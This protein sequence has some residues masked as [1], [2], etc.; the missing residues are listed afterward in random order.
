MKKLLSLALALVLVCMTLALASCDLLEGD[1]KSKLDGKTPEELYEVSQQKLKEATSYSV[2]STQEISMTY[3]EETMSM[4]QTVISKING[5]DSYAKVYS[6]MDEG[7]NM[8][9]WYVD[10]T[11]YASMDGIKAKAQITKAEYM[12]KYMN[13]DPSESTLLDIPKSWFDDIKFE[14]A[15]DNWVLNFVVSGEKYTELLSNTGVGGEISGDVNYQI[16]FDKEGNLEKVCTTFDMTIAGV[17]AHCDSVS[18][19]TLE[20]VTITPPADADSYKETKLP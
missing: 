1:T 4:T 3:G 14:K 12:Q 10:G 6:D 9:A 5:N 17:A 15:E 2:N 18:L 7:L 20:D 11:V 13:A 16:F 19:F 8:E